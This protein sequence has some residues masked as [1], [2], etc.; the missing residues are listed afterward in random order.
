MLA[1]KMNV[2][3]GRNARLSARSAAFWA[4]WAR[5]DEEASSMLLK[6]KRPRRMTRIY[7]KKKYTGERNGLHVARRVRESSQWVGNQMPAQVGYC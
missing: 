2:L 7:N 6:K 5:G 4:A 1:P 3:S